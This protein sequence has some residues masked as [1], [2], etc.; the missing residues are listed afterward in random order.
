MILT[1]CDKPK[2]LNR[3]SNATRPNLESLSID[4]ECLW[5]CIVFEEAENR[6]GSDDENSTEV[7]IF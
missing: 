2:Y 6:S 7:Q 5:I 1:H 3:F 4:T